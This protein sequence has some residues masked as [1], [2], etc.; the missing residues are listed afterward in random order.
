MKDLSRIHA[1]LGRTRQR[2]HAQMFLEW[3]VTG[4]P[5]ALA[6][7]LVV[8]WLWRMEHLGDGAALGLGLGVAGAL[9]VTAAALALRPLS[10]ASV[11]S[12]LDRASNLADRLGTACEFADRLQRGADDHPETRALM[13]AAIDDALAHVDRADVRAAAPFSPPRDTRAAAAFVVIAAAVATLGFSPEQSGLFAGWPRVDDET[14]RAEAE[15]QALR[16]RQAL[17]P[18]DLAYAEKYVAE[19]R[20]IADETQDPA[21]RELA[22]KIAELITKAERGDISKEELLT[23]LE[24]LDKAYQDGAKESLEPSLAEL[25]ESAKEL[26]KDPLTKRLGD[27]LAANDLEAA[28]KELERLAEQLDKNEL[29]PEQQERLAERLQKAA[30]KQEQAKAEQEKK[31]QKANEQKDQELEKKRD[32]VRKLEKKTQDEPQ[33]EQAKRQLEKKK[34]ELD[35]LERDKQER[36]EQAEKKG[37]RKLDRLTRNMEQGAENLKNRRQQQAQKDLERAADE[38]KGMKQQQQQQQNQQRT[39]SQMADLKEALRQ[40]K[41]RQGQGGQRTLSQL[42]RRKSW[43][44]RAGGQKPGQGQPGQK[45]GQGQPGQQPGQGQ[46]GQDGND[47]KG[48]QAGNEARPDTLYGDP[49]KVGRGGRDEH[50]GGVDGRGP[51]KKQTI[52]TAAQKGFSGEAYRRVYADYKKVVEEVIR[53]EKIPPSYRHIVKRY[54]DDII[55]PRQTPGQASPP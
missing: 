35:R 12:R 45:P 15:A 38:S 34:R 40:A 11:A 44:Q 26:Q 3:L 25:K 19:L 16:D 49:T 20:Q 21:L 37:E 42:G 22:D 28:A 9:V 10:R 29:S 32:E 50:L 52:V 55:S 6:G 48:P 1:L 2:L 53:Q 30:D 41:A 46:P 36:D 47:P 17:D 51:S 18:D 54:I 31:E 24:R 27:A 23:E 5:L 8:L 7:G 43:E 33:N 13:E 39:K 14:A 4:L